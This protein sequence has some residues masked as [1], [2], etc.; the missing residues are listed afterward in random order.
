MESDKDG[1]HE[2]LLHKHHLEQQQGPSTAHIGQSESV[3][4]WEDREIYQEQKMKEGR[5]VTSHQSE[6]L[7]T[8]I[9]DEV[10][11]VGSLHTSGYPQMRVRGGDAGVRGDV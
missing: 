2:Y 1:G 8:V 10:R 11:A 5:E 4:I 3:N 7:L 6:E 9:S